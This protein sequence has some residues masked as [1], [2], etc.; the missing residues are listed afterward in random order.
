VQNPS[1]KFNAFLPFFKKSVDYHAPDNHLRPA[2]AS[3]PAATHAFAAGLGPLHVSFSDHFVNPMSSFFAAAWKVL[4]L[5][6][7]EDFVSGKLLGVQYAANTIDP[8]GNVRDSSYS[9]LKVIGKPHGLA[10]YNNTLAKRI[11]FEKG[12]A[13]G[14]VVDS[15]GFDY[16]L[17]ATKEVILSAGAV[18]PVP[19]E[20]PLPRE[21]PLIFQL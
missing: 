3:V 7:A 12:S 2:N 11:L 13:T 4:G 18:R 17:S 14:V 19:R 15:K 8:K 6:V 10:V 16:V 20:L 1:Y 5:P 21:Q 9:F